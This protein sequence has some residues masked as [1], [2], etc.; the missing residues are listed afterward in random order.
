MFTFNNFIYFYQYFHLSHF[1]SYLYTFLRWQYLLWLFSWL[2]LFVWDLLNPNDIYR[3]FFSIEWYST[4]SYMLRVI[5][6][7]KPHDDEN[8]GSFPFHQL[9]AKWGKKH[10]IVIISFILTVT[11]NNNNQIGWI[12][13]HLYFPFLPQV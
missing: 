2:G 5:F 10:I 6:I 8:K 12:D 4:Y 7:F 3:C 9:S 1:S 11:I 13:L